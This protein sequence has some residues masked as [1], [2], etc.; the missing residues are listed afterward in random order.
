[1]A[2]KPVFRKVTTAAESQKKNQEER[3]NTARSSDKP[4]FKK[5][6]TAWGGDLSAV[7]TSNREN[8]HAQSPAVDGYRRR[9]EKY[10]QRRKNHHKESVGLHRER[11]KEHYGDRENHRDADAGNHG[12]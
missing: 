6:T 4:V 8:R 11:K 1:M 2:T 10:H 7:K 9:A 3:A 5:V 12:K